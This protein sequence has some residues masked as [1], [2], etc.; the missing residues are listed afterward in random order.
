MLGRG[1]IAAAGLKAGVG[2]LTGDVAGALT[3]GVLAVGAFFATL[4]FAADLAVLAGLRAD[5]FFAVRFLAAGFAPFFLVL[6]A[7]TAFF[8][9]FLVFFAFVFALFAMIV[10]PIVRG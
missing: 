8:A 10:L 1:G 5:A 2:A 9:P 6:R 3:S 4:R 7:A